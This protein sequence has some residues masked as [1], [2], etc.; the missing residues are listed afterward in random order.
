MVPQNCKP[1]ELYPYEVFAPV[2]RAG[3]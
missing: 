3:A 2:T 1:Q